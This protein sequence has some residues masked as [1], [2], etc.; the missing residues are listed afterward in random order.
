VTESP[1]YASH[2]LFIAT[3]VRAAYPDIA[4]VANCDLTA[5]GRYPQYPVDL[6][7]YHTYP[8]A[9]S[10]LSAA[11]QYQWDSY[12]RAAG[13]PAVFA[14]EYALSGAGADNGNLM[15]ALA[16]AAWAVGLERN[17]DVVK[18]ASYAPLYANVHDVAWA[19][20]AIYFNATSAYGTPS[21]WVQALFGSN[22]PA[23]GVLLAYNLTAVAPFAGA[24][25]LFAPGAPF[26]N[27]VPS[28]VT[29]TVSD[30]AT[31]DLIVKIVNWGGHAVQLDLSG[32]TGVP[33]A[34][35]A[36]MNVITASDPHAA[37]SFQTPRAVSIAQRQLINLWS[38]PVAIDPLSV[39]LIRVPGNTARAG[40]AAQQA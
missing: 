30:T 19:P 4:L 12:P 6:W 8:F 1:L 16:E 15:A 34:P 25:G 21:Y 13:V 2:Y 17:S 9:E 5:G 32:S 10:F 31:G 3:A 22:H 18:A 29:S 23:Q 7:D 20:D 40:A 38:Q 37:N 36:V 11:G 26:S 24:E 39:N 14:S 35:F 27:N 33:P 28:L